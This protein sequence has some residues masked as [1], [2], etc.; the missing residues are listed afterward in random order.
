VAR[1]IAWHL[2]RR[3]YPTTI[4]SRTQARDLLWTVDDVAR[5]S[6][7][8]SKG[9]RDR[10]S[11]VVPGVLWWAFQ[12]ETAATRGLDEAGTEPTEKLT[13]PNEG[14]SRAASAVVLLDEIDT[15]DPDVP[16]DRRWL[17]SPPMK[18][19]S[20]QR[21]SCGA[22]SYTSSPCRLANGCVRSSRSGSAGRSAPFA[23][24]LCR[25]SREHRQRRQGTTRWIPSR[26][27]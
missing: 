20:C 7:A 6:D 15:A 1:N 24:T 27:T 19:V 22:A 25:H 14:K 17:S 21:R 4:S 8:T 5:L 23:T 9:A 3:F 26:L 11:Y 12:P 2:K 13:D 18:S 10:E 16:N